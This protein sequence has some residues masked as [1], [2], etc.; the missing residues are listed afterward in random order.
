MSP[1]SVH[2]Y[3]L[4]EHGDS[5]VLVWSGAKVGGVPLAGFAEQSGKPL[6]PEVKAKIDDG[7][8]HAAYRI[9]EGKKATYYGIGAGLARLV[10]AIRDNEKSVWTVTT[11]NKDVK[12]AIPVSYALPRVVGREGIISTLLPVLSPDEEDALYRSAEI[13]KKAWAELKL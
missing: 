3:V 9:I 13:L 2:A 11:S 1:K 6:T 12:G 5:E 10:R 7:V 4:G 8:R